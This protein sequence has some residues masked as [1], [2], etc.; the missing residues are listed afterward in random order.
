MGN[1]CH[2]QPQNVVDLR[3]NKDSMASTDNRTGNSITTEQGARKAKKNRHHDAGNVFKYGGK[4][5]S[6]MM[7]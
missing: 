4:A 1:R 6:E 7:L 5:V 3:D 2:K